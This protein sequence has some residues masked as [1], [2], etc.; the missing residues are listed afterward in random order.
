MSNYTLASQY[1]APSRLATALRALADEALV[2][3][4]ALLSPGK[5]IG[6]VEQMRSLQLR[7]SRVEATDPALAESLRRRACRIGLR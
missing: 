4:Q 7:A 5:I 6:E 2:L 1:E 3:A